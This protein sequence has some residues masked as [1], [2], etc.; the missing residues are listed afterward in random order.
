MQLLL[1]RDANPAIYLHHVT[2]QRVKCN[3]ADRWGLACATAAAA[4]LVQ[5]CLRAIYSARLPRP[6]EQT[7]HIVSLLVLQGGATCL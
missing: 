4:A 2:G 6:V 3:V 1:C 7:R 5:V